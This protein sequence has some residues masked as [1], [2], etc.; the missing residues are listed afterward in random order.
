M[1]SRRSAFG[2]SAA[3]LRVAT[4]TCAHCS[5]VVPYTCMCRVVIMPKSVW[6]AVRFRRG[7]ELPRE[8]RVAPRAHADARAPGLA[9]RDDRHVAEAVVEGGHRVADL[10]DERAAPHR[11]AIHV[12][13]NDAERLAEQ[14]GRVL[15]GGEDAVHVGDLEP[16][17]PDGV[18][19]RLEVEREL[20]LSGGV[21]DLE[22]V[23]LAPAARLDPADVA[24][25]AARA[26]D[27]RI[28]EGVAARLTT[29]QEELP[30]P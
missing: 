30:L 22:R 17:V 2:L 5:S 19:D 27:A 12:A 8:A 29:G 4:A 28:E 3:H 20:A 10:D 21:G 1:G 18:G 15:T 9:V 23:E 25:V 11:G 14:R 6:G 24:R 26:E 7:P 13:R 16:G